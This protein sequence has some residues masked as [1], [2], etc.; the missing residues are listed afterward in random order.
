MTLPCA[1]SV[2]FIGDL[3]TLKEWHR[4]FELAEKEQ[5][6]ASWRIAALELLQGVGVDVDVDS[7]N[8]VEA[9][10][11]LYVHLRPLASNGGVLHRFRSRFTNGRG[12]GEERARISCV[13]PTLGDSDESL[14][15]LMATM[16]P[17]EEVHLDVDLNDGRRE[18]H[19]WIH[20]ERVRR[21]TT[22]ASHVCPIENEDMGGGEITCWVESDGTVTFYA[23]DDDGQEDNRQSLK[24]LLRLASLAK[25][26][27]ALDFVCEHGKP[28]FSQLTALLRNSDSGVA[29]VA[30]RHLLTRFR[31]Q[32][33]EALG[34]DGKDLDGVP[35]SWLIH[36]LKKPKKQ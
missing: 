3:H 24:K 30:Q 6:G 33:L 19:R 4:A 5:N 16:L 32:V 22:D 2:S 11:S 21:A 29:E 23:G 12:G 34:D 7:M 27:S 18:K 35:T 36:L 25:D 9:E 31:P 13:Y 8:L 1:N 26:A 14:V 17:L 28:T 10:Q 15:T 20:G